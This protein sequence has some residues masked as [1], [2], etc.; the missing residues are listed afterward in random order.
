[1]YPWN[2]LQQRLFRMFPISRVPRV[3]NFQNQGHPGISTL[4]WAGDR[5][6]KKIKKNHY[7]T[8]SW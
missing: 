4:H 6:F 5:K 3:K 2:H 1:M 7:D 8:G